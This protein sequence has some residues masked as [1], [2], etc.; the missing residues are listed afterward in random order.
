M[1]SFL[2]VQCLHSCLLAYFIINDKLH[3]MIYALFIHMLAFLIKNES[4][5]FFNA[6]DPSTVYVYVYIHICLFFLV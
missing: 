4:K 1:F 6:K 2:I 5:T 3:Y